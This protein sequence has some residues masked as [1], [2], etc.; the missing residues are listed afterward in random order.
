MTEDGSKRIESRRESGGKPL[1]WRNFASAISLEGGV[2]K[3]L[4]KED[5]VLAGTQLQEQPILDAC[6]VGGQSPCYLGIAEIFLF[7]F[8][9]VKPTCPFQ[10]LHE[11]Y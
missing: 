8:C 4:A 1:N 10:T 2:K 5:V 7:T 6:S 3:H 11:Q 9:H